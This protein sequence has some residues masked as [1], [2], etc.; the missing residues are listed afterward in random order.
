L[1][2]CQPPAAQVAADE[3]IMQAVDRGRAGAAVRR[4]EGGLDAHLGRTYA[5]GAELSGGQWQR[6]AVARGMMREAP[7]CLVLDEPTAA[8]DP[9]A[10]Q[11]LFAAVGELMAGDGA[12]TVLISH[13]FSTVRVADAIVVLDGGRIVEHGDHRQLMAAGGHYARMYRQQAE[14]YA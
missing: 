14:A 13:R 3:R 1:T 5:D 4:L 8:L 12:I 7:L 6:L 10:E 2:Y 11:V 9:E